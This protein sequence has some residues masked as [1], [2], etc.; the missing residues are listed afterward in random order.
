MNIAVL[1]T[2]AIMVFLFAGLHVASGIFYTAY[3][4]DVL[5]IDRKS[6]V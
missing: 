3:L 5:Y 2:V 1:F 4:A 6:V